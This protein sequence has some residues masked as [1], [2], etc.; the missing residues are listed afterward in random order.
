ML[1]LKFPL[2]CCGVAE[3]EIWETRGNDVSSGRGRGINPAPK[4]GVRNVSD[5]AFV[6]PTSNS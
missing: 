2:T 1:N 6:Q 5:A 3:R 4:V